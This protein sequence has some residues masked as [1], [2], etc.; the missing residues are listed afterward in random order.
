M[1]GLQIEKARRNGAAV[2]GDG[3]LMPHANETN[4]YG[5]RPLFKDT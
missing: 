4:S 1:Q 2:G 5:Q 3:D